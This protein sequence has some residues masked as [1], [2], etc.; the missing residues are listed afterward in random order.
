MDLSVTL[1]RKPDH[2]KT[3]VQHISESI[4]HQ[5]SLCTL[6]PVQVPQGTRATSKAKLR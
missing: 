2:T 3:K 5:F 4:Q 6:Q 1:M